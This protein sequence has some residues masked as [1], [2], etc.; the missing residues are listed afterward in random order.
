MEKWK[1]IADYP[2][3]EV[4]DRGQVRSLT[5]PAYCGNGRMR[6]V[7]GKIRKMVTSAGYLRVTLC[8]DGGQR[9]FTV[10]RLVLDAFRGPKPNPRMECRHL[11][12]DSLNNRLSNLVWGTCKENM[13]D[14]KRHGTSRAVGET[15][16]GAKLTEK[17]V[18]RIRKLYA[19][20]E[21]SQTA[22][23]AA[24]GVTAANVHDI[25]HRNNWRHI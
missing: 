9:S 15:N 7:V 18:L 23:A 20:G 24:Y 8:K 14:K 4:S 25:V 17:Q 19:T 10:H 22:L 11:D 6:L 16:P 13:A 12:G 1:V 3:Y 2:N 5:R 21:Y